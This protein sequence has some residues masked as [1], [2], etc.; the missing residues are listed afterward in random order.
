MVP[1]PW[2]RCHGAAAMVSL[3]WCR[4][5]GVAAMVPLP[6][7]RCHG[8]AAMVSLP[9]CR[10]HGAAAMVPLPWCRCHGVAAMVPLRLVACLAGGVAGLT[11][12]EPGMHDAR[13]AGCTKCRM[14]QAVQ[15]ARNVTTMSD[16]VGRQLAGK[17]C[18]EV[19]V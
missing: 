6:W 5:H 19:A 18:R 8:V 4:C 10:C 11:V 1:L 3:P 13:S 9:W 2:C 14:T 7:C 12:C 15:G 16:L 17:P